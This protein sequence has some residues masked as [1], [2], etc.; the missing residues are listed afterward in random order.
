MTIEAAI[1]GL[2]PFCRYLNATGRNARIAFGAKELSSG[3]FSRDKNVIA[4]EGSEL[5]LVTLRMAGTVGPRQNLATR[6]F[7]VSVGGI[8]LAG[9]TLVPIEYHWIVRL[10]KPA[11][12][13]LATKLVQK[14]RGF[15]KKECIGTSWTGQ[16]IGPLF[17]AEPVIMEAIRAHIQIHDALRIEPEPERRIVRIVHKHAA[18]VDYN[19]FDNEMLKVRRDHSG[20]ALLLAFEKMAEILKRA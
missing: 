14:T 5:D 13:W 11:Y 10:S 15:F 20:Q 12:P 2:E 9:R 3:F 1:V 18:T 16:L 4:L 19:L 17:D 7:G 6:S 8:P